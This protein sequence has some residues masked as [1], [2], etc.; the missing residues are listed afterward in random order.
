MAPPVKTFLTDNNFEGKTIIPF[1]THGG[2]GGYTIDK[3]M[4]K[5]AKGSIV[6]A[7]III[8]GKGNSETDKDIDK[9]LNNLK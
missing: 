8:Y 7:P 9:W 3:D 5:L 1:I 6:L 2:G 4:E